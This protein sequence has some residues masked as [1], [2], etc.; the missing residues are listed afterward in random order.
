MV[1]VEAHETTLPISHGDGGQAHSTA[2]AAGVRQDLALP[3]SLRQTYQ[4]MDDLCG[5][6][7]DHG[8]LGEAILIQWSAFLA[9]LAVASHF[10]FFI[11]S[12]SG[13]L[14][15]MIPLTNTVLQAVLH[16]IAS[17]N[18]FRSARCPM[19]LSLLSDFSRKAS[20]H[21]RHFRPLRDTLPAPKILAINVRFGLSQALHE[22][23]IIKQPDLEEYNHR[24][25]LRL[26]VHDS[27]AL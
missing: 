1:I 24:N 2:R 9:T 25:F 16:L 7:S 4:T 13:A 6:Q 12:F 10:T 22:L 27:T 5:H 21:V 15:F 8:R 18:I 26:G 17:S 23:V 14:G 3:T 20:H 11:I 19:P